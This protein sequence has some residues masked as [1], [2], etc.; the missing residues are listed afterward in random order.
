MNL[1]NKRGDLSS[2]ILTE[3]RIH[4]LVRYSVCALAAKQLG[5]MH[6][7]K[8]RIKTAGQSSVAWELRNRGRDYLWYGAKYYEKAIQLL[9]KQISRHGSTEDNTPSQLLDQ[10]EMAINQSPVMIMATD[11]EG[12][13]PRLI[14]ACIMI[15]YENLNAMIPAWSGHLDGYH[16]LLNMI[17]GESLLSP[18]TNSPGAY[19]SAE[20]RGHIQSSFWYFIINDLD[21]SCKS[22]FRRW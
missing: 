5:Q 13:K 6:D 4:P 22:Q 2:R 20:E 1:F 8:T 9:A 10:S 21:E 17:P 11:I 15:L 3:A 18:N 14:T 12:S 19:S 16:R 7:P